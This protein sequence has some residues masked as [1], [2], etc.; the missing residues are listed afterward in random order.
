VTDPG[1][2]AELRL[3]IPG[4]P[5]SQNQSYR[6]GHPYA[7]GHR[8]CPMCHRPATPGSIIHTEAAKAFMRKV[9]LLALAARPPGWSLDGIYDLECVYY[10][11]SR[12]PD[13]DGPGKL[14]RDAL[15]KALYDNDR[16]VRDFMQRRRLDREHPRIDLTLRLVSP[17]QV[18]LFT[19]S[20]L[21]T[22][23]ISTGSST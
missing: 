9:H 21:A 18:D 17:G 11:D 23:P 10:F 5:L 12:R 13:G 4:N 1:P 19:P 8:S 14:T 15:Q 6:V 20:T 22:Q 3:I 7:K 16:Q 2:I